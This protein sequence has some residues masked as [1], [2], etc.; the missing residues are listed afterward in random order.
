MRDWLELD[1]NLTAPFGEAL[2]GAQEEWH[3][4]PAPIVDISLDRDEGFGVRWLAKIAF[5]AFDRIAIDRAVGIFARD[6]IALNNW[7]E[8]AQDLDLLVA[9]GGRIKA[10]RRLHCGQRE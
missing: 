1:D 6:H 10:C 9:D 8:R 4:L 3:A 2:S 7:T 5:V